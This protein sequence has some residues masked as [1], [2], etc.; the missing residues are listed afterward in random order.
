MI[1]GKNHAT[2]SHS[3]RDSKSDSRFLLRCISTTLLLC[4]SLLAPAPV[5]KRWRKTGTGHQRQH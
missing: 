2:L 4:L 3:I 5:I 1:T